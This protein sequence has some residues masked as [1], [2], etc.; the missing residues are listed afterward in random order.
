MHIGQYLHLNCHHFGFFPD[1][2][3]FMGS[4][5]CNQVS[6]LGPRHACWPRVASFLWMSFRAVSP[7]DMYSVKKS[8][9]WSD[10]SSLLA[11]VAFFL[12]QH[13]NVLHKPNLRTADYAPEFPPICRLPSPFLSVTTTTAVFTIV[14]T[15]T[16]YVTS[17]VTAILYIVAVSIAFTTT[18]STSDRLPHSDNSVRPWSLHPLA[19]FPQSVMNIW[20]ETDR[21]GNADGQGGGPRED[22]L[23]R[24]LRRLNS[25][26]RTERQG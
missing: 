9:M 5:Q 19:P 26:Q 13:C 25:D 11:L 8:L 23:S 22:R 10:S 21:V 17:T 24:D 4:C 18:S 7:S 16:V 12:S 15:T 6:L 1:S 14:I 3:T 20:M 2:T